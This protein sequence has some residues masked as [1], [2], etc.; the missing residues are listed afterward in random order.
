[1]NKCKHN[2]L[3]TI[4]KWIKRYINHIESLLTRIEKL[5]KEN[6]KLKERKARVF[7]EDALRKDIVTKWGEYG[8][9]IEV[10][11]TLIKENKHLHKLYLELKEE[12]NKCIKE[13]A[14]LITNIKGLKDIKHYRVSCDVCGHYPSII[15]T[16][17]KGTFCQEHAK[18]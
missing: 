14:K 1:M 8:A 10:F 7:N 17:S 4:K 15:I 6:K 2:W 5:E 3:S 16:T 13:K 18:Y 9:H 11:D 12:L